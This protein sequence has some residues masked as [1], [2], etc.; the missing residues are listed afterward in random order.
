MKSVRLA[1]AC[2]ILLGSGAIGTAVFARG[3]SG[4][5]KC[6][7]YYPNSNTYGV[8]DGHGGCPAVD[9]WIPLP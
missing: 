6:N 4:G 5:P 2:L 3:S 7:C 1:L 9:C 8:Q